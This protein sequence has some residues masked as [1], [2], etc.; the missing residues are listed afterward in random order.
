MDKFTKE[1][2]SDI[3][4]KIGSTNTKPELRLFAIL[5]GMG[6]TYQKHSRHLPGKPDAVVWELNLAIFM[7]G[8]YWHKCPKCYK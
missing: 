4:S 6:V 2:R 8:C 5:D 7:H 1:K 3:M